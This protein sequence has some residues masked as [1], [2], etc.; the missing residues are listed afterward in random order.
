ME[1]SHIKPVLQPK[2]KLR[3]MNKIEKMK[4]NHIWTVKLKFNE[5]EHPLAVLV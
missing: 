3:Q 2:A 4:K 5:I 1:P